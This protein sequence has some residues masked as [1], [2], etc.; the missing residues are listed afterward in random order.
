MKIGTFNNFLGK[1]ILLVVGTDDADHPVD[2]DRGIV[3]WLNQKGA[4]AEFLP[5]GESGIKGNGHMMMLEK[6]SDQI[7]ELIAQWIDA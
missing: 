7:A 1:R 5:L 4:K 2:G 3:E 6:N